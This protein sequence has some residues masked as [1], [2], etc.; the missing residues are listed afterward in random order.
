MTGTSMVAPPQAPKLGERHTLNEAYQFDSFVV[1]PSNSLAHGAAYAVS[2][3]LGTVY[4]PLLIYGGTGLGKTHLLHAIGNEA[5]KRKSQTCEC[6]TK[7]QTTSCMN[8]FAQFDLIA[9]ISSVIVTKYRLLL[10]DDIQFFSK[11]EQTQETFFHI[12]NI[13]HEQKNRLFFQAICFLKKLKGF[14]AA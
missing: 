10:I 9:H 8:L 5:K 2:Q 6:A 11:K 3:S 7:P 14:K 1:G 13:L 12:F 4:N